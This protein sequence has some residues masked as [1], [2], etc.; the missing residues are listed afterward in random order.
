MKVVIYWR[1][2]CE[3]MEINLESV[4]NGDIVLNAT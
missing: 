2:E 1:C 3:N 4:R